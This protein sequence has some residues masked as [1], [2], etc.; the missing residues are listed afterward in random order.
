[1]EHQPIDLPA[2]LPSW[3]PR[4]VLRGRSGAR[5]GPLSG[6]VARVRETVPPSWLLLAIAVFLLGTLVLVFGGHDF[7]WLSGL[8]AGIAAGVWLAISAR[9]G[10]GAAH[11]GPA[12]AERRTQEALAPL[13]GRGWSFVHDVDG[14]EGPLHHIAVGPGG[15]ILLESLGPDGVVTMRGGE[16]VVERC[17][18][19]GTVQAQR[20]RPR[21][22]A[23]AALVKESVERLTGRRLWV[24]SLV[25]F[26]SDFPA[27]C[28]VDGH[29]VFVQGSRLQEWLMRRPHQLS[30]AQV[31]DVADDLAVVAE[32]GVDVPLAVAV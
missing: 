4:R 22:R 21:A 12:P 28:V 29:C 13:E 24:Q 3:A 5:S 9:R 30:P 25:V 2:D 23:D 19:Q 11:A 16:P 15:V 32:A 27:G 7:S 8:V 17:D 31:Q 20:L 6:T 26:W 10:S 1:M 18:E 14:P